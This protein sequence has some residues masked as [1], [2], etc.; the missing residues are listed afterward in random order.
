[1]VLPNW[2]SPVALNCCVPPVR[3]KGTLGVTRRP[4]SV[5]FTL[6]MTLLVVESPPLSVITTVKP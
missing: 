5:W 2:S 6:T 4:V 3:I 1:M